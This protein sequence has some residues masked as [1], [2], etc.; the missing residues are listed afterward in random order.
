MN[1]ETVAPSLPR[2]IMAKV[3]WSFSGSTFD[4]IDV[5][6]SEVAESQDSATAWQPKQVVLPLP[7]VRIA[8]THA[9]DGEVV[10]EVVDLVSSNG[11]DFTAADLLWQLHNAVVA[12]LRKDDHRYFQGLLLNTG[13]VAGAPPVYKIWLGS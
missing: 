4:S 6:S 1:S 5:F 7:Q 2:H 3:S 11:R 8:Y 10:D 12:D 9:H 13:P